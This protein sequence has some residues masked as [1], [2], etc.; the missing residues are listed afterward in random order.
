MIAKE[1]TCRLTLKWVLSLNAVLLVLGLSSYKSFS[2]I[3]ESKL[4]SIENVSAIDTVASNSIVSEVDTIA[5]QGDVLFLVNEMPD[6]VFNEKRGC[7]AFINYVVSNMQYPESETAEGKVYASFV[8]ETDGHI[9]TIKIVRSLGKLFDDEVVR[10]I[11]YAPRWTPG[12]Q[13]G[14]PARV[15]YTLPFTFKRVAPKLE[16]EEEVFFIIEEMPDFT[17]KRMHGIEAFR[18]YIQ[19]NILYPDSE[20]ID[21]KVHVRFIIEKDGRISSIEIVKS[22][23]KIFDDKVVEAVAHAPKWVPGKQRGEPKRVTFTIPITFK[24]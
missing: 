5:G 22:L 4:T 13:N 9:S 17:Y 12:K 24:R 11:A 3:G 1:K 2:S 21:G 19:D 8:V 23:G 18:N 7:N 20:S 14:I 6:F 16:E 10:A 15:G